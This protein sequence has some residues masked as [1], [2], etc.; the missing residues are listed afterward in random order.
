MRLP[1]LQEISRLV[2]DIREI[3]KMDDL[4]LEQKSSMVGHT[5]RLIE[6]EAS[7]RAKQNEFNAEAFAKK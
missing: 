4:T 3:E 6:K 5:L 2:K 1:Y 7:R